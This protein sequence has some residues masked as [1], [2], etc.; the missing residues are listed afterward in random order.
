MAR[1]LIVEDEKKYVAVDIEDFLTRP[2]T[3]P[4]TSPVIIGPREGFTEDIKTNMS[5]LRRRLFG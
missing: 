1:I 5:L 2:P 4:P 3:E